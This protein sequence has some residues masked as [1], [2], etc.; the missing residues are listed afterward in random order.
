MFVFPLMLFGESVATG[1]VPAVFPLVPSPLL[2][3]SRS[4]DR[5]VSCP[6]SPSAAVD[7]L[8]RVGVVLVHPLHGEDV[9]V[10]QGHLPGSVGL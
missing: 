10:P 8:P 4:P 2:L 1:T 5:D 7:H 3:V 9:D 6:V